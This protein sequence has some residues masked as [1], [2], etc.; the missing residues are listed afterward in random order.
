[1]FSFYSCREKNEKKEAA[2]ENIAPT[3]DSIGKTN[4]PKS[5]STSQAA[6]NHNFT[7]WQNYQDSLRK[8][9]LKRRENIILKKSFLQEM[10]IRNVVKV[11]NDT[12]F[13]IIPF[14]L[15]GADC[16]APDCYSTDVSFKFKLGNS[17][18]FPK[19]LQFQEYE[20]GCVNNEIK[21]SGFFQLKEISADHVI[22]HNI[23]F[24]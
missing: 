16:T 17:V 13:F 15:H 7:D 20:Y 21:I 19:E 24:N 12:L 11:L 23:S 2:Q 5:N 6:A 3:S 18:E 4:I 8:E 14:N 1:M 10:Y 22:Y 9:I